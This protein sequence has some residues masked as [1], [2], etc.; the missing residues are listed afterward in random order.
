M[1][2]EKNE[3]ELNDKWS[4][5]KIIQEAIKTSH[6][7]PS[8]ETRERLKALEVSQ[9][10][11]MQENKE[12]HQMIMEAVSKLDS[13]LDKALETKAGKWVETF[14][15]SAGAIIGT[16]LIGYLGTLLVKLISIR[17]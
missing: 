1:N 17:L 5:H 13:K 10:N 9:Q 3:Q 11:F 7:E 4:I 14:I 15:V 2:R 16:G 6:N 8:P 12:Q